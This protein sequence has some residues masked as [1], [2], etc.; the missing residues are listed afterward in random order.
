MS[1]TQKEPVNED[2]E[3]L[4]SNHNLSKYEVTVMASQWARHLKKQEAYRNLPMAEVIEIAL[5]DVL[6]GR[7]TSEKIRQMQLK[8]MM[9]LENLLTKTEEMPKK[10]NKKKAKSEK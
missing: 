6:T 9:N 5:K 8:D 2:L 10:G 1:T 3:K 4:I 7:V